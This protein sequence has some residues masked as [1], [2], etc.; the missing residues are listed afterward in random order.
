MKEIK[1]FICDKDLSKE[2]RIGK[3]GEVFCMQCGYKDIN[4]ASHE[5]IA[6]YRELSTTPLE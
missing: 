3:G 4:L 1:C 2:D 5:N 6:A